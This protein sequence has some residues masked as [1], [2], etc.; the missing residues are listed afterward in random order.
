MLVVCGIAVVDIIANDLPKVAC[1]SELIF[2]P[3]EVCEGGHACNVSSD[4]VQMNMPRTKIEVVFA[5]GNDIFG[6]FLKRK[7]KK[8]GLKVS[9]YVTEEAP[10]SKDMILVVKGEDRRF[11]V[12]PGAN[13]YLSPEFV[14]RV[15]ERQKPKILYIGG[16]GMLGKLDENLVFILKSARKLGALTFVDVVTPYKGSW[17]FLTTIFEWTDIFHCNKVELKEITREDNVD[18]AFEKISELGTKFLFITM[19][20]NGLIAKLPKAKI[21]MPAFKVRET[22]PTGAGDAFCAGLLFKI[23]TA[24]DMQTEISTISIENWKEFLL[25]ASACGAACCTA[26]G[27]TTSVKPTYIEKILREQGKNVLKA[28]IVKEI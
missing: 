17:D 27:A 15:I 28:T 16:V 12:D 18:Q 8:K 7:L 21:V 13:M 19:G 14:L 24:L 26:I 2:T 10:T 3:L 11:H 4:L 6:D 22:D 20:K 25:Y 23:F 9:I 1:P 5:V